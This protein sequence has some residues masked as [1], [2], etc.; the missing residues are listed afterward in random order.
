MVVVVAVVA[1]V[2]G[3]NDMGLGLFM[4]NYLINYDH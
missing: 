3:G 4:T 1:T 2:I